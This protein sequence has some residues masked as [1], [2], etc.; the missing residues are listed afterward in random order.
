MDDG[1]KTKVTVH[2][3]FTT[4]ENHTAARSY[5]Q[6]MLGDAQLLRLSEQ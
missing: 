1:D 4:E 5:A 6:V 2:C 3:V